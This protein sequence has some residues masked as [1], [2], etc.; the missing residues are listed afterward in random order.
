[1]HEYLPKPRSARFWSID[2]IS[3]SGFLSSFGRS[4]R[5]AKPGSPAPE[6]GLL[7][8]GELN[9][10]LELQKKATLVVYK[11]ISRRCSVYI[12]ILGARKSVN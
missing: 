9:G 11:V 2:F 8:I 6:A 10:D 4:V 3:G 1:M 5:N 7:S 12:C